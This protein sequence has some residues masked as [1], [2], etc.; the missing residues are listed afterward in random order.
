M[1]TTPCPTR[2]LDLTRS[3]GLGRPSASAPPP[4]PDQRVLHDV[5][6]AAAGAEGHLGVEVLAGAVARLEALAGA[7]LGSVDGEP[8]VV[9]QRRAGRALRLLAGRAAGPGSADLAALAADLRDPA[10]ALLRAS[11]GASAG[12]SR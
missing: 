1:T 7:S 4:V 5:A 11:A 10:A 12:G 2:P 6:D 8:L 3:S 9:L